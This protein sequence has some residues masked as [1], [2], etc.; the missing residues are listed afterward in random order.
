MQT[1][2]SRTA[3]GYV[4]AEDDCSGLDDGDAVSVN[5]RCSVP[6]QAAGRSTP[7]DIYRRAFSYK[8]SQFKLGSDGIIGTAQPCL[9]IG[10]EGM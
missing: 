9:A 4:P 2:L 6:L 1:F 8:G 10:G 5:L 7:S 3:G